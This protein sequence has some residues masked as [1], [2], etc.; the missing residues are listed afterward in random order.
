MFAKC[1]QPLINILKIPRL[2]AT[3]GKTKE[4]QAQIFMIFTYQVIK[5]HAPIYMIF[6]YQVINHPIIC[7]KNTK[8]SLAPSNLVHQNKITGLASEE[9]EAHIKH[10]LN[11]ARY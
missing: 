4:L 10:C 2:K 5:H 6:T 8:I 7:A 1:P 9:A 3:Q 11:F